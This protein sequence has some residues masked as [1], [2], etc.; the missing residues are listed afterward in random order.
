MHATCPAYL[1]LLDLMI[2]IVFGEEHTLWC[3]SLC[4]FLPPRIISSLS[5]QIFFSARCSQ[6][7]LFP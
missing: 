6:S 5:V 7:I 3:F 1:I 2:V 4:S